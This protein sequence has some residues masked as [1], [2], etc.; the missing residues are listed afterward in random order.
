MS[1]CP[2]RLKR[3]L[4]ARYLLLLCNF[5][6]CCCCCFVIFFS[7]AAAVVVVVSAT[8]AVNALLL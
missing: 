3:E 2:F 7:A 4:S 5:C 1:L 8:A 6:F